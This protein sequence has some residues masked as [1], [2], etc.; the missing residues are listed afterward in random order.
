VIGEMKVRTE[1]TR[2]NPSVASS[3]CNIYKKFTF[4]FFWEYDK[5][6]GIFFNLLQCEN[7]SAFMEKPR[8]HFGKNKICIYTLRPNSLWNEI[9]E[10]QQPWMA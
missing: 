3:N 6:S 10:L 7:L 9:M 4:A 5:Y 8:E 2:Y 1:R